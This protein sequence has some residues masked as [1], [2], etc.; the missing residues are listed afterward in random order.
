MISFFLFA[1]TEVVLCH[2]VDLPA[3]P[4]PVA[5][6][7]VCHSLLG[8]FELFMRTVL[9]QLSESLVPV[10]IIKVDFKVF[11]EEHDLFPS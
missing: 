11:V 3:W 10:V 9:M 2:H 6:L 5:L 1:I 7:S 4:T 8:V